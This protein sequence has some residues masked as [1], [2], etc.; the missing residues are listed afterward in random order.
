[1]HLE[2]ACGR[3]L[4]KKGMNNFIWELKSLYCFMSFHLLCCDGSFKARIISSLSFSLDLHFYLYMLD[5]SFGFEWVMANSMDSVRKITRVVP[6]PIWLGSFR[7]EMG[8]HTH[9]EGRPH[10]GTGRRWCL[11]LRREASEERSPAESLVSDFQPLG[12]RTVSAVQLPVCGALQLWQTNSDC[13]ASKSTWQVLIPSISECDLIGNRVFTEIFGDRSW[14][15]QREGHVKTRRHRD[16]VST[17]RGP[18]CCSHELGCQE[19]PE[20]GRSKE[21]CSPNHQ[22]F[23]LLSNWLPHAFSSGFPWH[24]LGTPLPSATPPVMRDMQTGHKRRP[25]L[26]D[27]KWVQG[28]KIFSRTQAVFLSL[29]IILYFLFSFEE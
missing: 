13:V 24:C 14:H 2:K 4:C 6:I 11:H 18:E 15:A 25:P 27:Y 7:R 8:T 3:C 5:Y 23:C 12:W 16:C 22:K 1:M 19:T 17:Q 9:T 20:A 21:G 26:T 28:A 10:E 29:W